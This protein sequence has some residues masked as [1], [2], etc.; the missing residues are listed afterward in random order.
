[1]KTWPLSRKIAPIAVLFAVYFPVAV[2]FK[3]TYVAQPGPSKDTIWLTG[4]FL[5]FIAGGKAYLASLPKFEEL[6]DSID[7]DRSPL[8]LYENDDALGPAH[9]QHSD[10]VELGAGRYSHWRGLGMV[11]SASDGSDPNKNW[12][13]YSIRKPANPY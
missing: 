8:V 2:Y 9:S 13:L 4:P 10:I 3:H 6:A 1:M 11:F 7:K 12:K 5:P